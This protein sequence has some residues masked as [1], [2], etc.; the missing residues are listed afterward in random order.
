MSDPTIYLKPNKVT[1]IAHAEGVEIRMHNCLTLEGAEVGD[2]SMLPPTPAHAAALALSI[3][4][5]AAVV[6]PDIRQ[7]LA[8]AATE[9]TGEPT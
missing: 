8:A 2:F 5:T 6:D 1:C 7:M 9:G 4:N 3:I